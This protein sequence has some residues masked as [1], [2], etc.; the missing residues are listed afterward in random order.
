MFM[1]KILLLVSLTIII[2]GLLLAQ[3]E[4]KETTDSTKTEA[5]KF[6]SIEDFFK[7]EVEHQPGLF[8]LYKNDGKL[9]FEIQDDLL[10]DEILV[11]SR[12][13]GHVKGLNFG[14]AGMRSRP[15]QVIRWQ[16]HGD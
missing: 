14:G 4:G 5:P 12:I 11:V 2:P 7:D 9:F 10:E 8:G 15:Q 1:K 16:K 6:K 13:K 3:K